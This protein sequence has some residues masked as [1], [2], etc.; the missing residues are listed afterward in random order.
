MG[1]RGS[2]TAHTITLD[3]PG[4]TG[5]DGHLMNVSIQLASFD[6]AAA[7][8][9]LC[10]EA[11]VAAGSIVSAAELLGI[12]RHALKRRIIKHQI[13]WPRPKFGPMSLA[14][15]RAAQTMV[16]ANGPSDSNDDD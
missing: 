13:E 4:K 1:S 12:T 6:L 14:A 3:S 8:K 16:P 10:T 9:L 11:L 5:F 2:D 7:E 15:A